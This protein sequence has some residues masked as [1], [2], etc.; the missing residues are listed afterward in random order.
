MLTC[1]AVVVKHD[2]P[3][4]IQPVPAKVVVENDANANAA[5]AIPKINHF[6]IIGVELVVNK[7]YIYIIFISIK[8]VKLFLTL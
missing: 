6:F 8:F 1:T 5:A 7:N 3:L 4:P 2:A